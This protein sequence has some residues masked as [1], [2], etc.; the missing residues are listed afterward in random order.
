M[1]D[2]I[3]SK[4]LQ[5][6]KTITSSLLKYVLGVF[7]IFV[8]SSNVSYAQIFTETFSYT[9]DATNGL[10]TQSGGVWTRLN[11][12]D[13]ILVTSG[14]LDYTGLA[15]STGNKISY[16]GT[17]SENYRTFTN[18][19]SGTVYASF[20]INVGSITGITTTGG[21][22]F[23]FVENGSTTAYGGCLWI[24]NNAASGTTQYNL[25]VS[26]RSNTTASF[27]SNVLELNTTYLVVVSYQMVAGTTN[28]VVKLWVNPSSLGGVEP[29]SLV[30]VTNS[31]TD[32]SSGIQKVL[33]RQDNATNTPSSLSIDEMRVGIAWADVT[34]AAGGG[35][36]PTITTDLTG[37]N[38]NFGA[39]L[40]GGSS[41]SSSYTVSGADLTANLVIHPPL[42]FEIRTGANPFSTSDITLVPSGGTVAATTIDVRFS[43]QSDG[44]KSDN[45]TNSS[46]GAATQSV[47]V[48][49][50]GITTEPTVQATTVTFSSVT[51]SSFTINFVA[52]NGT[53]RLVLVKASSAVDANP[54]DGIA[55]TANTAFGSGSQIGTGNYVV[56]NG[57]GT[58]VAVSGLNGATTYHVAVYEYN[59]TAPGSE[60]YKTDGPPVNSQLT[61]TATTSVV[62]NKYQNATPDGI[63]LL[64]VENNLDMRGMIIKDFSTNMG[65]DGGGKY[66]FTS[67][68]IWASVRSGTIIILRSTGAS[69]DSVTGG[70]DYTYDISLTN[71]SFFTS[72]GGTFDI[73]TTEL[74]MIKSAGSGA[75]GVGGSI[76]ALAGGTAGSFFTSAGTPKLISTGTSGTG[77]FVYAN[78]STGTLADYNGTDATGAASGLAFGTGNTPENIAYINSLR[79]ISITGNT[80]IDGG[81]YNSLTINGSGAVVTLADNVVI[82]GTL[83][84]TDGIIELGAFG[85]TVGSTTGASATSYVRTNGSGRLTINNI[86]AVDVD[87]PVGNTTFN[88]ITLWNAGTSDNFSV[89]VQNTFDNA[90]SNDNQAVQRQWNISEAVAGGSSCVITFQWNGSDENPGV[91]HTGMLI[92]HYTGGA[93]VGVGASSVSGSNPYR[94]S[95]S[96]RVTSFSPFI[97]ANG[98]VAP[99]ELASFTSS[100]VANNVKLNWST[101]NEE[102]NSGFDIERK[103]STGEWT[104]IGNVAGNGTSTVSHS[105]SFEDR[106]IATGNYN[107]RLKQIDFNGNFEYYSLSY[108]VIVGVPSKF[109]LSQNYPNPFNPS[110]TINYQLANNSFVSLKIYDMSGKE[111][112]AL[113]NTMQ[114]AGYYSVNF[115][116]LSLSSGMYFYTIKANDFVSTKRMMLV[117]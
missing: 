60:N 53:N 99:V 35:G 81:T 10:Q 91:V 117:K 108:E 96:E 12:G 36:T 30:S 83:T 71:T 115:N 21:Y 16:G 95:T 67:N 113:V 2:F 15:A 50:S 5:M 90:T 110:T 14:S 51:A 20:L 116:A 93:Y 3:N 55:Y 101:V 78:N 37:Y 22:T 46:T 26:G 41:S 84:L 111:V 97:V 94:I 106:N 102:N 17:G 29:A 45:I 13:S 100:T 9:A 73:S 27:A 6:K 114:T 32:F 49:G 24:R 54:V 74:V 1:N 56:Y 62:I 103:L 40:T 109:E 105:Y 85:L 52:G 68:D 11:T 18:Q 23:G 76:H 69:A 8:L 65:G 25:G 88:P 33:L 82:T 70:S 86:G 66:Q 31:G 4:N 58:T 75:T 79:N 104:K 98:G 38:G 61:L 48:S 43:P 42:N 7:M 28:D 44:I 39:V 87:F 47:P 34:P 107:Y 80:T 57:T 19:T 72:L 64:V 89:G 59:V 77:L 112:A 63:E 92:G